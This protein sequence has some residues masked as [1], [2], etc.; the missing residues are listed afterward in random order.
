[1]TS[2]ATASASVAP[3]RGNPVIPQAAGSMPASTQAQMDAAIAA[4]KASA[5]GW[6]ALPVAER[7]RL[8]ERTLAATVDVSDRWVAA[9]LKAKGLSTDAPQGGEEWLGGPLVTIR[10]LRLL[11]QS[12]REIEQH[13]LPQVP[14]PITTRPDGQVVARV[15]PT[16][17]YDKLLFQGFTGEIWMDPKVRRHELEAT[18]ATRYQPGA[19]VEPAVALVLGAGNVSSIGPMDV[20]YKLFMELQVC[21][22]KMNPVNE[23]LGPF[24]EQAFAP[25]VEPGYVRLVYGGAAE[26]AYLCQHPEV[27]EIHITGSDKTHDAIV[28]GVGPEGAKRKAER[29]PVN[30]RRITSELG[31]VSPVIVVPGPWSAGDL[32][33]QGANLASMLTNNAGCNC[34]ATRV[35]VQHAAWSQR[36]ALLDAIRKTFREAPTRKAYYPGATDRFEAF[37][38]AHPEAELY[39]NPREGEL[40]WMLVSGLSPDAPDDICFTTE[41][42][43]GVTSEVALEAASVVDYIDKA[44]AFCNDTV[45]GSLNASII[46]HPATLADPTVA[47]AVERAIADLRFGTVAVNHWPALAYGF[48]STT[49]G[50]FPGHELHDI[51]SGIGVVHNTYLY[52][53]PQKTVIRGP[54]R[55]KPT[56]PWFVT[57]RTTHELGPRMARF[58]AAPSLRKLPGVLWAA[59]RG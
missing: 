17:T 1:M 26:G 59:I 53:H 49:W 16:G 28:Y 50:A 22:L 38:K 36:L 20:L 29:D 5:A 31:N 45:W 4:V 51:Q 12:L 25:L 57:H 37:K 34:N 30:K 48:V 23:Y 3:Q 44:V 35:I 42:F 10:N 14:G 32:D 40:P 39:G 15:F 41:A 56:P 11:I 58:E 18:Q 24:I 43:T 2:T 7:V 55:V 46:V 13:G 9:A 52:E 47:A 8:L 21:V 54:F 33:F 6:V 19:Q 27:D